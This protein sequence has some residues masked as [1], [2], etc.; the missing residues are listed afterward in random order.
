MDAPEMNRLEVL[1]DNTQANE[2]IAFD[3][4]AII[5]EVGDNP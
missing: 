2:T 1:C 4:V 3:A 5:V